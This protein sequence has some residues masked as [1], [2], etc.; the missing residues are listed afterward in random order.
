MMNRMI[1]KLF[2][3]SL[4]CLVLLGTAHGADE[5]LAESVKKDLREHNEFTAKNEEDAI[6]K[7]L[8]TEG[9]TRFADW[10]QAAEQGIPEGQVLLSV[11][12]RFG[13][14]V[15]QDNEEAIKWIRKAAKIHGTSLNL[16][17]LPLVP[18]KVTFESVPKQGLA[19]A[20]YLLGMY[21]LEGIGVPTDAKKAIEWFR[22]AAEQEHVEAQFQL[23]KCYFGGWGVSEDKEKGIELIRKAAEQE[24][25]KAQSL[26]AACYMEGSG[27]P[28]DIA[29]AIKWIRKAAEQGHA[30]AQFILGT[31]Y[32]GGYGV[33]ED[34]AEGARWFRKAA[35]QGNVD[36]QF[37][38]GL[39]YFEGIGVPED[40]AEAVRWFRKAAE[41]GDAG[42]QMR[43]G[44]CYFGGI[45]VPQDIAEAAKWLRMAER[46]GQSLAT[47]LLQK[48]EEEEAKTSRT[49]SHLFDTLSSP[50]LT[51]PR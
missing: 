17:P 23:G 45:G 19:D 11:C 4:F 22:R 47:R 38:L 39:F 6:K 14:N 25:A 5:Q 27:V 13:I 7:R 10:K 44:A 36:A 24:H 30:V 40:K 12:Y 33:P 21:Y 46:Q 28:K 34:K 8:E 3:L 15:P 29:E 35:E 31:F 18:I 1:Q 20:Q 16:S 49:G 48:I 37:G 43:L 42:A 32:F 51:L 41:Q 9:A 26:L 2:F 50:S